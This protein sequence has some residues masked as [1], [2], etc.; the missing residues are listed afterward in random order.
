MVRLR[1]LGG[2]VIHVG[3]VA[4][5]PEAER[6]FGVLLYLVTER[7]RR[8]ARRALQDLLWPEASEENGRHNLRQAIYKL[9]QAGVE[10]GGGNRDVQ[11][12]ADQV[13]HDP[14]DVLGAD[15]ATAGDALLGGQLGEYLAGYSPTFSQP[16]AAWVEAQRAYAH[17]R[18][19]RAAVGAMLERRAR[20]RWD[21]VE[22]LAQI[23]LRYD[24]LNEEATLALAEANALA[25]SKARAL[26]I[27]DQYIAELG[28]STSIQLPA[29]LLRRRIAERLPDPAYTVPSEASFAG[30]D[31]SLRYLHELFGHAR[32]GRGQSCMLVG[33]PGVGKTRLAAEFA[34]VATLQ[35]AQ[36]HHMG[37]HARDRA[38]PLALFV[39]GVAALL[40][41]PGAIGCSPRSMS[42]LKRIIEFDPTAGGAS[43][44]SR[45]ADQLYASVRGSVLDLLDAICAERTLLLVIDDVHWADAAS[46]DVLRDMIAWVRGRR[47]LLVLTSR[48]AQVPSAELEQMALRMHHLAP[49]DR[50]AATHVLAALL[51]ERQRRTTDAQ[52]DWLLRA[53]N[54]NPLFI[55]ELAIHWLETGR[56]GAVPPSLS[57]LMHARLARLSPL[58]LRVFQTCAIMGPSASFERLE[59]VLQYKRHEVLDGLQELEAAG[60]LHARAG[61]VHSRHE[62]LADAAAGQLT[63]AARAYVHRQIAATLEPG[64]LAS[65]PGD[66]SLLW[67]C[68][69]HWRAAGEPEHGTRVARSCAA[70]LL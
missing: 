21:E 43:D 62:L 58:G 70:H 17:A 26:A 49:L 41:L 56:E 14:F 52:H 11:L 66:T 29:T 30:R 18:V 44:D 68:A 5:G 24:P 69:T 10:L 3:D 39:D 34:R 2:C 19:A 28:D 33:E 63:G 35:G 13:A 57:A 65:L 8:V 7:G 45:E 38:R 23:C 53:A 47:V 50:S 32:A 16:Y 9:R 51:G 46:W 22:R 25:G 67:A 20:G 48:V 40:K 27:L 54:G 15:A 60:L 36:V 6:L 37:C 4:V 42:Y 64:V 31:E 1:T 55:R 61:G 59:V 12:H